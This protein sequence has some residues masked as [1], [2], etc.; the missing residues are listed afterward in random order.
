[1]IF[2]NFQ[3]LNRFSWIC[4]PVNSWTIW[5]DRSW[6]SNRQ[7]KYVNPFNHTRLHLLYWLHWLAYFPSLLLRIIS[8]FPKSHAKSILKSKIPEILIDSYEIK[9]FVAWKNWW[10]ISRWT[11]CAYEISTLLQ[12]KLIKYRICELH[13]HRYGFINNFM[14]SHNSFTN[15]SS[16]VS[17]KIRMAYFYTWHNTWSKGRIT[18]KSRLVLVVVVVVGD[19]S[20]AQSLNTLHNRK[21]IALLWKCIRSLSLYLHGI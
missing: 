4:Y 17:N 2:Y 13:P 10:M 11:V 15:L 8:T 21:F 18:S 6:P 19:G 16:H 20:L 12:G 5:K 14:L 9:M 7:W 1:M 3:N